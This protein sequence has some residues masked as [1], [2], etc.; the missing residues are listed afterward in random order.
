MSVFR[1]TLIIRV[2]NDLWCHFVRDC[3]T[4]TS[5]LFISS[6]PAINLATPTGNQQEWLLPPASL[7]THNMRKQMGASFKL[8]LCG[9]VLP[10]S[11]LVLEREIMLTIFWSTCLR[12]RRLETATSAEGF[13]ERMCSRKELRSSYWDESLCHWR[14]AYNVM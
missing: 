11:P 10:E 7:G 14:L 1:Y 13:G 9:F 2:T 12:V 4:N 5:V 3:R 8:P 6:P